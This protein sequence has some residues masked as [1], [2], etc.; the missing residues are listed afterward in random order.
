MKPLYALRG[1]LTDWK[2]WSIT[3]RRCSVDPPAPTNL[4]PQ[5]SNPKHTIYAFLTCEVEIV[6]GMWKDK[7]NKKEA[8]IGMYSGKNKGKLLVG[9]Y[10]RSTTTKSYFILC[11]SLEHL[12]YSLTKFNLFR[13]KARVCGYFQIS[14]F[15]NSFKSS[16]KINK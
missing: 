13:S 11:G 5:G 6:I 9:R 12:K 4:R 1:H 3:G 8:R 16:F 15:T 14:I 7:M 2:N 10:I